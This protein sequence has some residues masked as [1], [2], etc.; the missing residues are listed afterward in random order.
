MDSGEML[1]RI[2]ANPGIIWSKPEFLKTLAEA[3]FEHTDDF[4]QYIWKFVDILAETKHDA[5]ESIDTKIAE[6]YPGQDIPS[7][8][9]AIPSGCLITVGTKIKWIDIP[10]VTDWLLRSNSIK[11]IIETN[12]ILIYSNGKYDRNGEQIIK[13]IIEATF[14]SIMNWKNKPILNKNVVSEIVEK[15]RNRTRVPIVMINNRVDPITGD[16]L[17]NLNNGILNLNTRE[18]KPHSADYV[19]LNKLP[20]DYNPEARCPKYEAWRNTVLHT[21]FH[22]PVDEMMGAILWPDYK[23][24][25]AF[26]LYGGPRTGKGTLLRIITAMIGDDN[27]SHVS[28]QEFATDKFKSA[29]LFGKMMNSYGDLPANVIMDVGQFKTLTGEDTTEY[30]KKFCD[31]VNFA[32]TAK[33]VFGANDIPRIKNDDPA[34]YN[35]WII[36]TF[37]HSFLGH[38]DARLEEEIK[39]PEELSGILNLALDGLDRLRKNRWGMSYTED[40]AA[41]YRRASNPV[42]A[43]LED[44]YEPSSNMRDYVTK[45][46]LLEAYKIYARKKEL[47]IPASSIAFNKMVISNT[48][49]PVTA[50]SLTHIMGKEKVW[51]D[52]WRGIRKAEPEPVERPVDDPEQTTMDEIRKAKNPEAASAS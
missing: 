39:T 1:S 35:R 21:K 52:A 31:S 44:E 12:E 42:A 14:G 7:W 13:G 10:G 16:S 41:L 20:I 34:F 23:I 8:P 17:L 50:F 29:N 3:R 25:K 37:P 15:I 48:S 11:T 49:I 46:E 18:L 30:Q 40:A 38:E 27:C 47:R 6:L 51:E 43:F 36:I 28:L 33:L 24:Q 19:F 5:E 9:D 4:I 32:N 22:A 45:K 26:M 2:N